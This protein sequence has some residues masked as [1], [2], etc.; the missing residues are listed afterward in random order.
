M[1]ELESM[2]LGWSMQ[3]AALYNAGRSKYE[4]GAE[5]WDLRECLCVYR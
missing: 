1:Y 2:I 3:M 4:T 5:E